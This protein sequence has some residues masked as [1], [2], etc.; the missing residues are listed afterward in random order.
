M[1]MAEIGWRQSGYKIISG[2][3]DDVQCLI[4]LLT[5]SYRNLR[6]ALDGICEIFIIFG[7]RAAARHLASRKMKQHRICVGDFYIYA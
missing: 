1:A 5:K 3:R 2:T 4:A 6:C 7:R